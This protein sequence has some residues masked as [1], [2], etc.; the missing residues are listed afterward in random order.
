MKRQNVIKTMILTITFMIMLTGAKGQT[1]IH[2]YNDILSDNVYATSFNPLFVNEQENNY[3]TNQQNFKLINQK[4]V[5]RGY[6]QY[7]T[8]TY[9][10][11]PCINCMQYSVNLGY[12]IK[13]DYQN[14]HTHITE[15]KIETYNSYYK[16]RF[17]GNRKKCVTYC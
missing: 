5:T 12:G 6:N 9:N 7:T 11:Q 1:Y 14:V 13:E 4:F 17:A 16:S 3:N 2:T 8:C 10:G 15:D